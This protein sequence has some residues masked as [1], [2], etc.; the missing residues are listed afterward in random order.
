[1]PELKA[2][3]VEKEDRWQRKLVPGETAVIGRAAG[4]WTVPWDPFVSRR[5]AEILW[6]EDELEVRQ[7]ETAGNPI[8]LRGSPTPR[9]R[10]RPGEH[11]VIGSTTF[12]LIEQKSV[13]F[14]EGGA[15]AQEHVFGRHDLARVRYRDADRRVDAL[16]R[17]PELIASAHTNAEL[18]VGLTSILLAGAPRADVVALVVVDS[19]AIADRPPVR[20]LHWDRRRATDGEFHPSRRLAIDALRRL[21]K[22]VVYV[23]RG[24]AD[25]SSLN[26]SVVD[27]GNDWAFCTP[28]RGETCRGWGV[29]V[30]GRSSNVDATFT[31]DVVISPNDLEEDVKFAELVAA[32]LTS[33]RQV[34][35]LERRHASL[36]QFFSPRVLSKFAEEDP[37]VALEPKQSDV[38]VLFCDLRGFSRD[39]ESRSGD[40]MALLERV[41]KALGVMTSN[42]LD[43]GGVVGD[44]QGDAAMG[45]WGWPVAQVDRFRRVCLAALTIRSQFEQSARKPDHPLHGFRVGIGIASG[46][47]VAGKIGTTDQAKIGVFGPIVNL[48]SRLEGMSKILAAPILLDEESAR[49]AREQLSL[50]EGRIRRLARVRPA[51]MDRPIEVSELLPPVDQYPLLTDDHIVSYEAAL[52]AFIGG[53]W[54]LALEHFHRVPPFDRAQDFMTAYIVQNNRTPPS[55]WNGVVN[56][57]TKG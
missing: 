38:S 3:G 48:A 18:F 21:R 4:L 49:L 23:W 17:L 44:F 47:A 12:S 19:G 45:F 53:D 14:E 16:S 35:L 11:F 13:S 2:Q 24:E 6:Q 25:A 39:A 1:M 10:I 15:P 8:F 28:V 31:R 54:D 27:E 22:S 26:R 46:T 42:I 40:L 51:G 37:E 55:D 52:D 7:L 9:F 57:T 50:Q 5:H 30:A 32:I 56:L 20:V 33:L 43:Q 34:R 29:Y 36:T 41:S